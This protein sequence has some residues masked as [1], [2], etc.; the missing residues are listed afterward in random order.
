MDL[1]CSEPAHWKILPLTLKIRLLGRVK[2]CF[3]YQVPLIHIKSYMYNSRWHSE[4]YKL[5]LRVLYKDWI[6]FNMEKCRN[7]FCFVFKGTI[8]NLTYNSSVKLNSTPLYKSSIDDIFLYNS[9][10]KLLDSYTKDEEKSVLT[11]SI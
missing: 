5:L 2:K 6:I 10:N 9:G 11:F 3:K 7:I 4:F 1:Q 8:V